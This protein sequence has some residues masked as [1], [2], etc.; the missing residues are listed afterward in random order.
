ML[1]YQFFFLVGKS[2]ASYIS[3]RV[4]IGAAGE[5]VA[6]MSGTVGCRWR[7]ELLPIDWSNIYIIP[8]IFQVF[9]N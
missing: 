9:M 3:L 1:V 8:L 4:V 6:M 7:S 5:L 2:E